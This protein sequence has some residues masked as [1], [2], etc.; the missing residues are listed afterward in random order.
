MDWSKVTQYGLLGGLIG[1]DN[2]NP[3]DEAMNQYKQYGQN[4][5][6][7]QNPFYTAG[8][9]AIGDYQSWL[10]NMKDPAGFLNNL[11]SQYHESPYAKYQQNQ[12]TRA[13]QNVGSASGLT[14]STPL[15]LQAQENAANISSQDQ[16][17]WLQN[18]L[19][20][21]TQYGQGQQNLMQGGQRSADQLSNIRMQLAQLMGQGAAGSAESENRDQANQLA[22]LAKYLPYL[23]G[24]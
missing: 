5:E 24:L 21:N 9:G 18:A 22:M 2:K 15:M 17:Q 14:G 8:T 3:F 13:A 23:F 12:A 1:G 20:I 10:K 11:T 6:E 19:G 7:A 16:N 4:A